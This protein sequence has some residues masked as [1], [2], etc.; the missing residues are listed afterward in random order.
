M[1]KQW[2]LKEMENNEKNFEELI[3]ML[4]QTVKKLEDKNISLE[5]AV[6]N[7]TKGLELSKQCYQILDSNEK[8]IVEKMT[9]S[10]LEDFGKEG[11]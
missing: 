10:G 11:N 4:E 9:E 7:Y 6:T 5:D 3:S 1:V 2:R 8:L